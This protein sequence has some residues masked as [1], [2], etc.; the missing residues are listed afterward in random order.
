MQFRNCMK[1][2]NT[3]LYID[4]LVMNNELSEHAA[5][6]RNEKFYAERS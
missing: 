5:G 4:L 6:T 2:C 3:H 1:T